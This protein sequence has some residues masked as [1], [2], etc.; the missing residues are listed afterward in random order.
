MTRYFRD[1]NSSHGRSG[2]QPLPGVQKQQRPALATLDQFEAG[3]GELNGAVHVAASGIIASAPHKAFDLLFRP[4][5]RLIDRF[6]LL[7]AVRDQFR[8]RPLGI[9]LVGDLRRRRG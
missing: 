3:A 7:G 4:G 9:H 2:R 8:H 6:A 5:D 1:S